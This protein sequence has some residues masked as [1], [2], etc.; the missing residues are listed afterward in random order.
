MQIPK[1]RIEDITKVRRK[2]MNFQCNIRG[3]R[4]YRWFWAKR[5][6]GNLLFVVLFRSLAC[7]HADCS[8]RKALLAGPVELVINSDIRT[9]CWWKILNTCRVGS[10]G[11]R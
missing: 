4:G 8:S 3:V 11:T 2:S 5:D 6:I 10:N 7:L 1:R 9:H